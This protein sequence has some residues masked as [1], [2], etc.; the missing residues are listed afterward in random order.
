MKG[1]EII[2]LNLACILPL[3]NS[4]GNAENAFTLAEKGLDLFRN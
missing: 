1:P 4:N 2:L 3:K